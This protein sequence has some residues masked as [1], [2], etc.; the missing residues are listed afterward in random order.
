MSSP[1]YEYFIE[2]M[3][4]FLSYIKKENCPL[5]FFSWHSYDGIEN[6]IVYANYAKK[7]LDEYGYYDTETVC[8]EWLIGPS[9]EN[10]GSYKHAALIAGMML[11]W[12]DTPLNSA[13]IYDARLGPSVYG[14]LFNCLTYEP[15]PAYYAFVAFNRLYCLKNQVSV[16]FLEQGV[17]AVAAKDG[18]EGQLVIANTKDEEI[19]LD[20][21]ANGKIISC[22]MLGEGKNDCEISFEGKLPA[23]SVA[24]IKFKVN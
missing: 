14:A 9:R 7:R 8:N 24:S 4:G 6:N 1:R 5:D 18:G 16:Q 2:F 11:A 20:I 13:M 12:Q 23:Y 21:R 22:V 15:Y 17:Y 10:R 3:E 19:S